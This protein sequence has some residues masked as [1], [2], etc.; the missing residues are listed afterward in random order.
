TLLQHEVEKPGRDVVHVDDEVLDAAGEVV[1]E[2]GGRDGDAESDGR[3]HE[4]LGDTGADDVEAAAALER[5]E[6][7]DDADD[8]AEQS[9]EGRR[10]CDGREAAEALAQVGCLALLDALEGAVD[11]VDHVE[12][13]Y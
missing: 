11:R 3:G 6:G 10:R 12:V 1:E 4:R 5:L 8:G 7:V 13:P 9:D 2:H